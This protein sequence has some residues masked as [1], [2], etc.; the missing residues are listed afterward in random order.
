MYGAP[1]ICKT[2]GAL[3]ENRDL[4]RFLRRIL[5]PLDSP[6]DAELGLGNGAVTRGVA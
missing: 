2:S 3:T 4:L 5:P 1:K 6:I